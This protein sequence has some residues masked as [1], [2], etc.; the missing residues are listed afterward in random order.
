M[1]TLQHPSLG[2]IRGKLADGVAQYLG[3]KYAS[4]KHRFGAPELYD[5]SDAPGGIDSTKLGYGSLILLEM[6]ILHKLRLG[7]Q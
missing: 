5:G 4:L 6:R 2:Q 3:I 7:L 1:T